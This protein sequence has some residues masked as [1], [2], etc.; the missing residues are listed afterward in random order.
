MLNAEEF[1]NSNLQLDVDATELALYLA[2][3]IDRQL[4]VELGLGE[5]IHTRRYTR[6]PKP[7]ITTNEI[8][9]RSHD[10]VSKFLPPQ[11]PPTNNQLRI[12]IKLGLE[13]L[14]LVS[15]KNHIYSF[16]GKIKLQLSGGAIGDPLTGAIASVYVINWCRQFKSKLSDLGITPKLLQVCG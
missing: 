4:L 11:S 15:L 16:D 6:G 8:L 13:H 9:S 10:T 1:Y 5:V 12:M 7:G 14:M 2:I 3:V